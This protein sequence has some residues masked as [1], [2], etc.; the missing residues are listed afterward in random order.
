MREAPNNR[1]WLVR[2]RVGASSAQSGSDAEALLYYRNQLQDE[3]RFVE[4]QLV[5][6]GVPASPLS[7][8]MNS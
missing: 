2:S 6:L 8:S 5:A 7:E 4:R 1:R 3:L